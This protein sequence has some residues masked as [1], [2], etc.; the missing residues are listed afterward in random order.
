MVYLYIKIHIKGLKYFGRTIN[1]PYK[2]KGSGPHWK[3]YLKK[4]GNNVKTIVIASFEDDDPRL[5]TYAETFS[6][7]NDIVESKEWANKIP[8][9]GIQNYHSPTINYYT[10]SELIKIA[11]TFKTRKELGDYSR[12]V[13]GTILSRGLKEEC[14]SHMETL[15]RDNVTDE[16]IHTQALKY[17]K[18]EDW[19]S[20]SDSFYF[21]AHS[22]GIL[23]EVTSHIKRTCIK[24]TKE[25]ITEAIDKCEYLT[26]FIN[27]YSS[28]Y[29]ISKKEG[30]YK[31]LTKDLKRTRIYWDD[32]MAIK[33]S[34]KYTSKR[35]FNKYSGSC[36]QY[37]VRNGLYEK[38]CLH[39]TRPKEN[40]GKH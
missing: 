2:Y 17:N 32:E 3:R 26:D 36:A 19:K 20:T 18:I 9:S 25:D 34:K 14:F 4:Y 7:E 6:T 22:R 11:K 30:W 39:M 33:E 24:K 16:E 37:C 13:Y 8:E 15:R 23:E 28:L 40:Y 38:A 10:N 1:D 29:V 31:E 27:R 35:D 5:Q 21:V 12:S